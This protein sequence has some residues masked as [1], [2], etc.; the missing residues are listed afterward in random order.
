MTKKEY[1]NLY[2]IDEK[3]RWYCQ[4]CSKTIDGLVVH[5]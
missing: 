4:G 3:V 2:E 1:D 5:N